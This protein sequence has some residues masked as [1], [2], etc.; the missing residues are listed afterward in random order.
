[1]LY[2]DFNRPSVLMWSAGNEPW[3]YEAFLTYLQ[4]TKEFL[5]SHDPNRIFSFA[6]VS[7]QDWSRF[8]RE[9]PLRIVTPNCYGGTFEGDPGAWYVEITANLQ[10][11]GN[12]N[13]GKP[14]VNMEWGYWRGGTF[15]QTTCFLEGFRAFS[16]NPRVQ[17]FTWW[18]AFDYF[19]T[20]YYN[21]MG[22]YNM[23]RTW[24]E[25]PT[26]NAMVANYTTFT[27]SNL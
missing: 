7:S 26:F 9:A 16:E 23:A 1:M 14:I 6:C 25:A 21:G 18:L 22:V 11:F 5:D 2:R 20:N 17:G 19:G 12:N 13:P 27:A 8:F 15:N 4:Q 10:R 3:A 24:Y